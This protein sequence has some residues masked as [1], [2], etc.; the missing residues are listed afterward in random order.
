MLE[1]LKRCFCKGQL[2]RCKVVGP[3]KDSKKKGVYDLSMIVYDLSKMGRCSL[4]GVAIFLSFVRCTT[5]SFS[6]LQ[7]Q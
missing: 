5:H 4:K 7:S 6:K 3:K 2:V 1:N